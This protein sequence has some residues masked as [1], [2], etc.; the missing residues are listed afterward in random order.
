VLGVLAPAPA[1]AQTC[2][3]SISNVSFGNVNV[4]GGGAV[5]VTATVT[6]NCSSFPFT[7]V[8]VCPSIGDGSGGA[9]ATQRRMVSG[10]N[11]LTYQLYSNSNRTTI[12][13]SYFWSFAARP[14]TVDLFVGLSGS[15][16]TTRTIFAR[17]FANQQT[18]SAGAYLSAF[19]G[20]HTDFRYRMGT[21]SCNV[22]PT[23]QAR[24]TFN[25]TANVLKNCLV[26]AQDIDFGTHGVLASNVDAAGQLGVRC[27]GGT[28]YTVGLD[29]GLSGGPPTARRLTKGSE[30][31]TYGLYRDAGR[32]Q[33]WGDLSLP[34]TVAAGTGTGAVQ[35]FT[36]FGRVP[37][38]ATPSAGAYADTIAVTVTY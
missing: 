8:R 22:T 21:T 17:V 1:L 25:V 9:T 11:I 3:F 19:S 6:F 38:Q 26:T 13:G 29:G 31:I 32:T 27:T 7:T 5:D 15:A 30:F 35:N 18:V 28:P 14:P 33:P 24:P 23:L 34:A 2:N 37:P 12:W 20:A 4:L 36:V 10:S 16:S